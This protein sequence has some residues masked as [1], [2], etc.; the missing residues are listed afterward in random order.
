M[1]WSDDVPFQFD[2]AEVA[3]LRAAHCC[4]GRAAEEH[5]RCCC[6]IVQLL[7]QRSVCCCSKVD[8][9]QQSRRDEP[10]T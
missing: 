3:P 2:V 9:V 5:H 10:T 7:M 8:A 6:E 1:L 4:G